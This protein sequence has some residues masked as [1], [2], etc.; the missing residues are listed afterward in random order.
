VAG[1]GSGRRAVATALAGAVV[2]GGLGGCV[3]TQDKNARAKLVA[4]RTLAGRKPLWLGGRSRDVHVLHVARVRGRHGGA[5]VVALRNR[6]RQALTDVPIAVGV[7]AGGGR[8]RQLN[9]GRGLAWFQ[10]HVPAIGAGETTTW[11]FTT[12]RALPGGRPWAVAGRASPAGELPRIAATVEHAPAARRAARGRRVE[13]RRRATPAAIPVT[14]ANDSDIPQYE[15]QVYAVVR[16]GRRVLAAGTATVR[17]LGSRGHA[18]ARIGLFGTPG[19]HAVRVHALP[20]I[21]D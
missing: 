10:T 19:D 18:S 20:T 16:A 11:I 3:S 15:L 13:A 9:G 4:D 12:R 7:V 17:H 8:R 21:F 2:L 5:L 1:S 6:G 14:L